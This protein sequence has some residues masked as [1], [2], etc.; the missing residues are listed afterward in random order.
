MMRS[1]FVKLANGKAEEFDAGDLTLEVGENVIVDTEKGQVLGRILSAPQ[2]KEKPKQGNVTPRI[3]IAPLPRSLDTLY[4]PKAKQPIFLFGMLEM[5]TRFMGIVADLIE[6][7]PQ[8][9]KADFEKFRANYVEVSKLVSEWRKDFP[10][11][12]VEELGKAF[13]ASA[14]LREERGRKSNRFIQGQ[15]HDRWRHE[16]SGTRCEISHLRV[17]RK[18]FRFPRGLCCKSRNES[19]D[20]CTI[21]KDCFGETDSS[22]YSWSTY[23]PGERQ[24]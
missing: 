8:H 21:R 15:G 14:A 12:P 9:A 23:H 20:L 2:E 19:H 24:L 4:P 6:N 22:D 1:V 18:H 13:G 10:T 7:E 16:S 17:D 5:G 11:G 3:V